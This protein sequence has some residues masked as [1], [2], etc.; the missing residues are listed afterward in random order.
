MISISVAAHTTYNGA[1]GITTNDEVDANKPR[2][3]IGDTL[4]S[5]LTGMKAENGEE[6][7]HLWK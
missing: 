5:Y 3:K 7:E 2:R 6:K 4:G 1:I